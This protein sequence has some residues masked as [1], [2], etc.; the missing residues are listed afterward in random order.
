MGFNY[1]RDLT[2]KVCRACGNKYDDFYFADD[3]AYCDDCGV[4]TSH[5]GFTNESKKDN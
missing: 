3:Y 4:N 1:E 2:R 5:A